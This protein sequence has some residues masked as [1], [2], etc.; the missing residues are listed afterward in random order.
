MSPASRINDKRPE[1]LIVGGGPAG[2]TAAIYL[3][4][5]R[6]RV[7]VVD[8]GRSRAALIPR[9]HNYPGY[10]GISGVD[11]L[12][13]LR[14]Q[15]EE[16]GVALLRGRVRDLEKTDDGG[17]LARIGGKEIRPDTVLLA[18]GVVDE[19]PDL[20]G[21]RSAIAVGAL[22]YCPICDGYEATDDRL[23]VLGTV[24]SAAR[25]AVFLRTY[26]ANVILLPIMPPSREDESSL[27]RLRAS[28][29]EIAPA[30][31][32]DLEREGTRVVAV[33]ADGGRRQVDILYAALGCDVRS[34]LAVALGAA[35][36]E[37]GC[38]VVDRHQKT[39]IFGLFAAGDVVS[40][41]DQISVAVGHAA[42][43]ATAIHNSLP[44]NFR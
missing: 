16:Y 38:L 23:G 35:A 28:G 18:T 37:G 44:Y 27:T 12:A 10:T 30:P 2:L 21:L 25:K 20:P 32:S 17:F 13:R 3:A 41:L 19:S 22:R 9:S 26:S 8:E 1:C 29:V 6:R 34:E 24:K 31:V 42:I 36:D 14:G 11:L 33:L 4:R 7:L 40:D 15:A 5:F 43:A 39:S